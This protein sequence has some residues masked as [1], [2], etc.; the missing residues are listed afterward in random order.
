MKL[1]KIDVAVFE[2]QIPS[3]KETKLFRAYVGREEKILLIAKESGDVKDIILSLKQVIQNCCVDEQF[4]TNDLTTF[5]I[6]YLFL[7]LRARSVDNIVSVTYEDNEDGEQYSFDVNLNEVEMLQKADQDNV[8]K[9]TEKVGLIMRYPSAKIL[10]NMPNF[11]NSTE[12]FSYLVRSCIKEVYDDE[13]VYPSEDYSVNDLDEYVENLPIPVLSKIK[14]FLTNMPKMHY[15]LEYT[16][17]KGT[18]RKI[19]LRSLSDFFTL[20]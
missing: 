17:N 16:N 4:D 18:E 2:L 6:E 15:E 20:R 19:V 13:S 11:D 8:I 5:D 14:D 3:T 9:I 10:N 12:E 1:P 7:K